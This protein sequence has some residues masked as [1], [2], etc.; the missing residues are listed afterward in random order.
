MDAQ[1]DALRRIVTTLANKNEELHNFLDTLDHTLS[2]LQENA[3]LAS[4]DLLLE[5]DTLSAALQEAKEA[6]ASS[7]NDE[8]TRKERELEKQLSQGKAALESSE[9]LLEFA[10][11]ALNIADEEEFAVAARQIKERVTMAPAFRLTMRP[12]TTDSMSHLTV[13][14]SR[15]R[16]ML[17]RLSF[18]PVPRAPE[19]NPARCLVC[20]NTVTVAWQQPGDCDGDGDDCSDG[21]IDHYILEY[22]KTDHGGV[23]RVRD[24]RPWE[25]V[26]GI[27]T[28]EYTLTGLKFDTAFVNV[29][30]RA[31]NK[32]AAGEYSEPVSLET[33]AFN[34]GFDA[35][36]CH[37][38]LRVEGNKVEWDPQGLKTHDAKHKG[39]E[40][41]GRSSTPSPKKAL[42]TSRSPANRGGR[43]RFTGESYTV[44]GDRGV[45]TG[46]H[47]WEVRPF[48]D[49]KSYSV[50]VAYRATL[51]KFDQLGKSAGA[52]CLHASQWLQTSLAA[53]HN[54]RAKSLD[55]PVPERI[56]VYCDYNNGE[57]SFYNAE[58]RRLLHTFRTKF[59]QPVVPAFMVWCGGM[60]IATGLQVPSMLSDTQRES[61]AGSMTSLNSLLS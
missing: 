7:I 30:V 51:G 57:L 2:G 45:D 18:L 54:N 5:F 25:K 46:C 12:I 38:N 17:R 20:N 11:D 58:S 16:N 43:D 6:L 31:C 60:T 15:E 22:Q 49:C 24:D 34:F 44:L 1:K 59:T 28:T 39:Q 10:N 41:K 9:E 55:G 19:I 61:E 47:Y 48:P 27:Q 56:G 14:F 40:N 21:K 32:A 26:D 4:S 35:T 29:R 8:E 42:S 3:S 13:D 37:P 23:S 53:K 36:T 50:G 33:R 52:W